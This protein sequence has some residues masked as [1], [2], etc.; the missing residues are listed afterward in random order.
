CHFCG[1]PHFIHNCDLVSD[2]IRAG[3]CKRSRDGKI[4]LPSG[5]FIPR[6]IPGNLLQERIDGWH[7]RNPNHHGT[8]TMM[9]TIRPERFHHTPIRSTHSSY[10]LSVTDRIAAVEAEL[11]HLRSQNTNFVTPS[12][13][14]TQKAKDS[15]TWESMEET[16]APPHVYR[17]IPEAKVQTQSPTNI[18]ATASIPNFQPLTMPKYTHQCAKSAAYAPPG[19]RITGAP[20][21]APVCKN[22][23]HATHKT[24]PHMHG[25]PSEVKPYKRSI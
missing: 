11:S 18:V 16:I 10:Q 5:A 25:P 14:R 15:A 9:Y 13:T 19:L 12:R 6:D 7:H 1:K 20:F 2:Y 22:R 8:A 4:V 24:L 23:P 17:P 21:E 3:K